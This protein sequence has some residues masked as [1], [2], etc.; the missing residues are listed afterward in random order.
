MLYRQILVVCSEIHTKHINTL[1]GQNIGFFNV[2]L[3]GIYNNHWAV[4][5]YLSF[6]NKYMSCTPGCTVYF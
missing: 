4:Y 1:Y 2:E 6:I 3:G 5:S